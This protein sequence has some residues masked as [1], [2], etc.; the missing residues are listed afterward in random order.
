[1]KTR[2]RIDTTDETIAPNF[3]S[4]ETSPIAL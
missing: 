2:L 1:V 3:E 4:V